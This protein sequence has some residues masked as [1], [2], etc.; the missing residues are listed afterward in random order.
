MHT[1][2]YPPSGGPHFPQYRWTLVRRE[3]GRFRKP[4]DGRECGE[5]VRLTAR[6]SACRHEP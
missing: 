5:L 4:W 6:P 1:A 3:L 2:A